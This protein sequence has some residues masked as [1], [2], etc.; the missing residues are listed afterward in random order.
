MGVF[1]NSAGWSA[2]DFLTFSAEERGELNTI[3]AE[4]LSDSRLRN[5]SSILEDVYPRSV[6]Y[7]PANV[8]AKI[9]GL[10]E[11]DAQGCALIKG[12]PIDD[13]VPPTPIAQVGDILD[14]LPV[15]SAMLLC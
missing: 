8:I 12:L 2:T 10:R 1:C 7:I 3:L 13:Q 6:R 9:I 15:A 11:V 5:F 14:T 4:C